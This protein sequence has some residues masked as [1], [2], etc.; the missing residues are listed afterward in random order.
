MRTRLL[1]PIGL[2]GLMLVGACRASLDLD[3]Y[4]FRDGQGGQGGDAP[5]GS[6]QGGSGA[7]V[8]EDDAVGAGGGT[9]ASGAG[10]SSGGS[11]METSAGGT[12]PIIP[13]QARC[14]PRVEDPA[15]IDLDELYI[16]I[17]TDLL[18]VD[19]SDRAF[20]RYV[21]I[22]NRQ[23][24]GAPACELA[25]ERAALS[26]ALNSLSLDPIVSAPEPIDAG[27]LIY[28]I[29]VRHYDW[30]RTLSVAGQMFTDGWAALTDGNPYAP[31]FSGSEADVA[32]IELETPATYVSA[33]ALI[34]RAFSSNARYHAL[35]QVP[36]TRTGLL[37]DSLSI[38]A[39]A[40]RQSEDVL[41]AGVTSSGVTGEDRA[42]ERFGSN[43][44]AAHSIWLSADLYILDGDGNPLV[45]SNAARSIF[46]DPVG[47][48]SSPE[49]SEA[50]FNLPNGLSAYAMFDADEAVVASAFVPAEMVSPVSCFGCHAL[51]PLSVVDEVRSYVDMNRTSYDNETW[52][53]VLATYPSQSELD[54][55]VEQDRNVVR[56]ALESAGVDPASPDP[57]TRVFERFNAPLTLADVAGE[58]SIGNTDLA[59]NLELLDARLADLAAGGTIE[60]AE[61]TRI[62]LES[63][64]ILSE[65]FAN[66]PDSSVCE[67]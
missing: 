59:A 66:R 29:D 6:V 42:F 10:G 32:S 4:A 23:N 65:V 24:A 41:R 56:E 14:M 31:P 36:P 47:A 34:A 58:L 63:L 15:L 20:T 19:L 57:I 12:G 39:D 26:K 62:Y 53:T 30:N 37:T 40:E 50:I 17:V 55:Q 38:D 9:P 2:S 18:T 43:L 21:G 28:R 52:E 16:N 35:I 7:G 5:S 3:D 1:L 22:V 60:R 11:S 51:G 61:F 67:R 46:E 49:R 33:D 25:E 48:V 8:G 13:A 64:C 54:R 45:T 27:D 44:D